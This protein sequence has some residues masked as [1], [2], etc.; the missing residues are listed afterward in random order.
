MAISREKKEELVAE[1]RKLLSSSRGIMFSAYSGI[2]VRDMEDLRARIREAGGSFHVVK[3]SLLNIAL[4]EEGVAVPEGSLEG[5]TAVGFATDD[6]PAVAKAL[7]DLAKER[8][9]LRIK[10]AI[11]DGTIYGGAKVQRLAELPPLD[12][13]RSQLIGVLQAPGSRV[14]SVLSSSVRQVVNVV[15]AYA[16]SEQGA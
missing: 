11:V 16:Q 2:T 9:V 12:I 8:D 1:Y 3:N 13:V 5:T 7:V 10:S 14:A 4:E 15:N 6:V